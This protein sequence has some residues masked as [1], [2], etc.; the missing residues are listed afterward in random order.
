M[1][2]TRILIKKF[3]NGTHQNKTKEGIAPSKKKKNL[4]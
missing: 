3:F 1:F 4:N 2:G